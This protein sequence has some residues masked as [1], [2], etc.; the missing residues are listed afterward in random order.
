MRPAFTILVVTLAL[1]SACSRPR[2]YE[3]H[4][5]I[6]AVD[7]ARQEITIKH[8][9]IKGFMP[10]MTMP[11]KVRDAKLLEGR[12]PGDLVTATLVVQ[13]TEGYLS[14]VRTTGHAPLTEPPP[15]MLGVDVLQP[16]DIVPDVTLLDEGGHLRGLN[17]WRG[18]TLAVTFIYTRCPMPDFCPRMDRNFAEV[19]RAITSDLKLRERAYLLSVSFDP[20]YDTP[21]VLAEH[22]K[23]VGADPAIWNFVT[24]ERATIDGFVARFGVSVIRDD[25]DGRNIVHNLRTAVIAGNG[26]IVKIF[27]GNDWTPAELIVAIKEASDLR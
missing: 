2:E 20:A 1:V 18:R 22:A 3:L 25:T 4:G 27:N 14:A 21:A 6:L 10:G 16:G 17:E 19:Q 26:R 5:Q 13:D 7:T 23:R 9:D 11:F 8:E 15:A 12:T 24:G